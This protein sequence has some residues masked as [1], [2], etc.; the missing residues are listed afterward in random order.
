MSSPRQRRRS[1][2]PT[3][4]L[5]WRILVRL[6]QRHF[7]LHLEDL[8]HQTVDE[9]NLAPR[10]RALLYE[11]VA[12]CVRH[13]ALLEYYL[14][15]CSQRPIDRLDPGL[16]WVLILAAYQLAFLQ[17]VPA[18]AAANETVEICRHAGHVAWVGYANAVIRTFAR[19]RAERSVREPAD[20]PTRYSHPAWIVQCY[21]DVFGAE[22][23]EAVLQ[24]NNTVPSHY[25]RVR[26]NR[27]EIL[28]SLPAGAAEPALAFGPDILRVHDTTAVLHSAAFRE[29]KLYLMQPWSVLTARQLGVR[30]GWRVLDMCAAPGGKTIILADDGAHVVALDNSEHRLRAL[31]DNVRRCHATNVDIRLLDALEALE[32]FGPRSFDAVLLDAPCANLGVIQRHPEIRWR[33]TPDEPSRLARHQRLL[34]DIAL[35]VVKVGG[36]VLYAVCSVAPAE[37]T[38]V[39]AEISDAVCEHQALVRPGERGLDGGYSALLRVPNV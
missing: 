12:G 20:L 25:A 11:L 3:R 7:A 17:R 29:G 9:H 37:T 38:N 2:N 16:R 1:H 4:T 15:Q 27:D 39:V 21:A 18:H 24:W 19:L 8:V 23:L 30:P 26:G 6:E 5:A 34:L 13:K 22:Q 36:P 33:L 32:V 28:A 14:T 35:R 31:T 10:D